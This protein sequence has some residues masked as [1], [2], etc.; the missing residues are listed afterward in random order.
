MSQRSARLWDE[1]EVEGL[2]HNGTDKPKLEFFFLPDQTNVLKYF[3]DSMKL[4]VNLEKYYPKPSH[5]FLITKSKS[6][7]EI[8]Q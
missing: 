3:A 1:G 7:Q 8:R 4:D 6:D 5:N 2:G